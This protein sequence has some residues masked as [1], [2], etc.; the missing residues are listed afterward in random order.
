VIRP[1]I[2]IVGHDAGQNAL[3]RALVIADLLDPLGEVRLVAFGE[4]L[5][6][7]A[8]GAR[9]VELLNPP[10]TT[11]GLPAAVRDL[12][13]AVHG[14][15]IIVAVKP[16]VLSYGLSAMVRDGRPL[17]LDIDDL[18]YVFTR[19]R[20]GWLRQLIEPD[21]EPITRLLER[22]RS[23]VSAIT[24]A[25]R[26]LQRRYGGTWLPHVRDRSSLASGAQQLGPQTRTRLDLD[27]AFVVGFVGTVRPHKG[28]A[29]LADA[30]GRLGPDSRLLLAGDIG[31]PEDIDALAT[32]TGGRLITVRGPSL[33]EIGPILGACDVVAIPQSRSMESA[34]QSP[35]KLL[36]ALAAGKPVVTSD[37]GDA[38]ELLGGVGR[39]VPPDDA[40]ALAIVLGE[41]RDDPALR[42]HLGQA[43]SARSAEVFALDRWRAVVAETVA[44]FLDGSGTP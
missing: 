42:A 18:E 15:D 24:V 33:D 30:V 43:A 22:W 19:R 41:L 44:P 21:R 27:A 16:R 20:L 17:I 39:L 32:G 38:A 5:W 26:A 25:S 40:T 4:R 29:V 11:V 3:G 13:A 37:I 14:A 28:L 10:R 36:D 2:A 7:P 34:Y 31:D 12:R 1:R 35:A 6:P 23:P 8:E 9:Q